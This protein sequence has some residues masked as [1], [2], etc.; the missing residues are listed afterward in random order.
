M[1]FPA[2]TESVAVPKNPL[3]R[4]IGQD[5][6]VRIAR[7]AARQR[8]HLLLVG[9]PGTGKS[10]LAQAISFLVEKPQQEVSVLHNP[11]N[12]ERPII[13]I[14]RGPSVPER[15]EE[16]APGRLLPITSV[17]VP[18]AERLGL[19]CRRCAGISS[20][21]DPVCPVCG[22]DKYRRHTSPFD[23]LVYS[24]SGET[25][26]DRVRMQWQAP[27]GREEFAVFERA[28]N[29]RIRVMTED[30]AHLVDERGKRALR[31]VLLPLKRNTFVQ[32]TGASETELLGDVKHD[33]YGG[34]PE[35]G[36]QPYL[37][38]VPGAVHEAHEGVLF[39]D[40]ISTLGHLQRFILTAMQ[41][42]KFPITGRNPSS[43]GASVR[44]DGVPCDFILAAATNTN[45][46]ANI[47]PPLRSRIM[48][49]GYE[50]LLVNTMPDTEENR[51]KLVQFVAQE[52]RKDGRIPHA[53]ADALEELV[54]EARTRARKIDE[55]TDSLTLRLRGLSGLIKLAGDLAAMDGSPLIGRDH[56]M[57][58]RGKAATIEEQLHAR[59]GSLWKA[60][61]SDFGTPANPKASE[62]A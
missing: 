8:R 40:E 37:R 42:K 2:T 47:L 29:G 3:E 56:V 13:E 38:V 43:T 27:G 57:K 4:V 58:A 24:A 60:G 7:I 17:P 54:K 6:A 55:A 53:S 14:R 20:S 50:V 48:G 41:E 12:P 32:A 18:V 10:M 34:H 59:Y 35:A 19:R 36:M 44:V 51:M 45:D 16:H 52:I 46:V 26:E 9:A 15:G 1:K 21:M 61:M 39:V 30:E 11:E 23:D 33:P 62:V 28:E 49:D 31:K 22:A 25:R 5:E